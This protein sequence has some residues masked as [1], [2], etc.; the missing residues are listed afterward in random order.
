MATT[1]LDPGK[2]AEVREWLASGVA[3]AAWLTG[4][5]GSGMTSLVR[6]LTRDMEAVWLTS[7]TLRSRQFLREVCSH[8]L[9]VNGKRKVLVLDELDVL[10]GN[11]AVMLDVAFTVR[12]NAC[13]PVVC[14]LKSSR[15]AT[16]CEL[17]KK[18]ALVVHFP[19]PTHDAMVA[20][21]TAVA[22][23]EGLQLAD[24]DSLC[25]QAPGDIRHVLQTMR[26]GSTTTRS[27]TMQTADAVVVLLRDPCD[28]RTALS[29]YSADAGGVPT[30]VFESYWQTSTNIDDVVAYVDSASAADVVDEVIHGKHRWDLLDV[31]G[32]LTTASAAITLPKGRTVQLH[33]YGAVWNKAYQLCSKTKTLKAIQ[34]ARSA[35]GLPTMPA[36]ELAFLRF[37]VSAALAS[38]G[39]LEAAADTC[40]TAGLDA[41]AC[42]GVMRLWGTGYRL[43]THNKLKKLL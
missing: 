14:I 24:I 17:Q 27:I 31:H 35:R 13:I 16:V 4:S 22:V 28:V 6:E 23:A 39:G 25:H 42:L 8:P 21:V 1:A 18:A 26:A 41:A 30:G 38:R 2:V 5:P 12:H 10:L 7:A 32:S 15:V 43:G 29:L 9:A 33:K 36:T 3:G 40:R 34:A 37:M 19:P 11:E 20:A